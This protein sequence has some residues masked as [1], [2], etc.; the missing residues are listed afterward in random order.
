VSAYSHLTLE[1][2]G[3]YLRFAQDA[4]DA[5]ATAHL[6]LPRILYIDESDSFVGV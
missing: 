6:Q 2:L 3:A 5:P 4:Y 1:Q